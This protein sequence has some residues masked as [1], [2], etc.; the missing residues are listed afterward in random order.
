M[1]AT[2][3]QIERWTI[4]APL[5][6]ASTPQRYAVRHTI[7]DRSAVLEVWPPHQ[8]ALSERLVQRARALSQLRHPHIAGVLDVLQV[9]DA[10]AL[11]VEGSAGPT[12]AQV[13][14][15]G[16]L[17]PELARRL[18]IQL[19]LA[20]EHAHRA[21]I[22]HHALDLD[23]VLLEASG[24]ARIRGLGLADLEEELGG[25]PPTCLPD[26]PAEGMIDLSSVHEDLRA[27]GRALCELVGASAQDG[28]LAPHAGAPQ[29]DPAM[30]A[31]IRWMLSAEPDTPPPTIRD[32]LDALGASAPA[33]SVPRALSATLPAPP[34]HP[35]VGREALFSDVL[36]RLDARGGWVTLTGPGGVG[37]TRLALEL[38]LDWRRGGGTAVWVDLQHAQ[39][40]DD[41]EREVLWAL[42]I[43]QVGAGMLSRALASLGRA[44]LV[45]DNLE[46]LP[47]ASHRSLQRWVQGSPSLRVLATSRRP[48]RLPREEPWSVSPLPLPAPGEVFTSAPWAMLH[49]QAPDPALRALSATSA[50]ALLAR[51]EGLPLSIVLAASRLELLSPTQ[52][53]ERLDDRL[54]VLVDPDE[55]SARHGSL[56]ATIAWSW[57]LLGA[58]ERAVL[59]QCS[60]FCSSFTL[61]D[62]EQVVVVPRGEV[63]DALQLLLRNSLIQKQGER[64]ALLD[65]IRAFARQQLSPESERALQERHTAW[66][67]R[68]ALARRAKPTSYE[69]LHLHAPEL[70]AMRARL[71]DRTPSV[72]ELRGANSLLLLWQTTAQYDRVLE[73]AGD[74]LERSGGEETRWER[75]AIR[76]ARCCALFKVS[77]YAEAEAELRQLVETSRLLGDRIHHASALATLGDLC[78]ERQRHDEARACYLEALP[79]A[80][81]ADQHHLSGTIRA[82]L[83]D[84]LA[85]AGNAQSAWAWLD[86]AVERISPERPAMEL[87]IRKIEAALALEANDLPRMRAASQ[88]GILLARRLR[89]PRAEAHLKGLLALLAEHEGAL[90]EADAQYT[91]VVEVLRHCGA[92]RLANIYLGLRGRARAL[93]DRPSSETDLGLAIEQL[94]DLGER[95]WSSRF[96]G[97]LALVRAE[98]HD[99]PSDLELAPAHG[100]TAIAP[101]RRGWRAAADGDP[102]ATEEALAALEEIVASGV[103]EGPN[104]GFIEGLTTR[105]REHATAWSF[106]PDGTWVLPFGGEPIDLSRFTANARVLAELLRHRLEAPGGEVSLEVLLSAGWPGQ[107][108]IRRAASNRVSVALSTLRRAG[109]RDLIQRHRGG[110]LLDPAVPVRLVEPPLHSEPPEP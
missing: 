5:E 11:L 35:L 88:R 109:L 27:L 79:L 66:I 36:A 108:I 100:A 105:L 2:G 60:V 49:Q 46:Q 28:L 7:L 76:Y 42:G 44:L 6:E 72:D 94:H 20:L 64:F 65:S 83:A 51:L 17:A 80:D 90:G 87:E 29:L 1:L 9:Q 43:V 14:A 71:G 89:I 82:A 67:G 103:L 53:L 10:P 4:E 85:R 74:L 21:G 98:H 56:H 15:A 97:W 13:R 41:L 101:L 37:K 50:V 96:R 3:A 86:E 62:A 107:Q 77:R 38:A 57:S 104:Q 78:D 70:L 12:L 95:N 99:P 30:R 39:D 73:L 8:P 16:P 52:L 47:A 31:A 69:L 75:T 58:P 40:R 25:G 23:H 110:W 33:T 24:H 91:E 55:P 18:A 22:A 93:R 54:A 45:L 63:M 19:L 84:A 61:H 68:C 102:Q 48:L 59:S 32:L 106:A 34:L 26:A 81:A 92:L